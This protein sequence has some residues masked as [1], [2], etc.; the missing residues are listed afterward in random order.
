[1]NPRYR[2]PSIER[3]ESRETEYYLGAKKQI[4]GSRPFGLN[5]VSR[6]R[7]VAKLT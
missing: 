7:K 2:E 1:M 6:L 4:F 3:G 5:F